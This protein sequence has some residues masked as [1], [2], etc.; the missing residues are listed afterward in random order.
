[1]TPSVP[2]SINIRKMNTKRFLIAW[3]VT[4]VVTFVLNGIFHGLAAAAFFDR[5]LEILGSAVA[6]MADFNPAPVVLLEFIIVFTLTWIL[7]KMARGGITVKD[8][9]LAGALLEMTTAATWSLANAATFVTWS[10][11]ITLADTAWHTGVG[12]LAG[13]MV[14]RLG[15]LVND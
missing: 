2:S 7:F 1:M 11:A 5:N 15:K 3:V 13:W 12:G 14:C 8:A 4:T 9:V 6:K 10:M